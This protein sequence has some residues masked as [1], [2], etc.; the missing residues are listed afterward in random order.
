[1]T[2]ETPGMAA[3]HDCGFV[4]KEQ[5]EDGDVWGRELDDGSVLLVYVGTM[6]W[7][8]HGMYAKVA[9]FD[10]AEETCITAAEARAI[11]LRLDELGGE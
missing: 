4:L 11:A 7:Y 8:G 3:L 2:D 1:M 9:N 10:V 6:P 5:D